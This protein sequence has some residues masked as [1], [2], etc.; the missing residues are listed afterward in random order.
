MRQVAAPWA[1]LPSPTAFLSCVRL[2]YVYLRLKHNVRSS[3]E[4]CIAGLLVQNIHALYNQLLSWPEDILCD[5]FTLILMSHLPQ[6][7]PTFSH[8]FEDYVCKK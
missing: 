4:Y 5:F 8:Q 1:S 2:T 3:Y 7:R 6:R